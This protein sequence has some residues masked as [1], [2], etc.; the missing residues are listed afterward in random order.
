MEDA[1]IDALTDN[2]SAASRRYAENIHRQ[3]KGNAMKLL[4]IVLVAGVFVGCDSSTGETTETAEVI[5]IPE[6]VVVTT[7]GVSAP[8]YWD[9]ITEIE[10]N[11][12]S[13]FIAGVRR[14]TRD[15][16]PTLAERSYDVCEIEELTVY[17]AYLM[18][19]LLECEQ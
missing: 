6:N 5:Q 7:H 15:G 16:E 11:G 1:E 3:P 10:E 2:L 18:P 19:M 14:I 8:Q 13:L 12:D 4:M 9:E 17:P